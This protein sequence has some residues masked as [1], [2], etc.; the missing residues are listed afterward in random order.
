MLDKIESFF[1]NQF[2]GKVIARGAVTL[3]GVIA[4]YLGS[5][6]AQAGIAKG[7]GLLAT[8]G[9]HVQI[10]PVNQTV[11]AGA[12][13]AG[14]QWV[15]EWFKARRAANPASPTVQTDASKPGA[16]VPAV[17]AAASVAQ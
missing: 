17:A 1:M 14:A 13:I 11:L 10:D 7:L 12:F 16:D 8:V 15:F 5:P 4:A 3:A 2:A 6:A 9:L